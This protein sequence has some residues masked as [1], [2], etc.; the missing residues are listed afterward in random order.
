MKAIKKI[1]PYLF[2]FVLALALNYLFYMDFYDGLIQYGMAHAIKIG[3]LPY[4]DFNTV[5][6]PLYIYLIAPF[7]FLYDDFLTFLIIN[8]ILYTLLYYF[9]NKIL[10]KHQFT[11][12]L[13]TSLPLFPLLS[14]SYNLLAKVLVLLIVYFEIHKKS[15]Y[16]I[17]I[18]LGL[19]IL[20]KHSV[21]LCILLCGF[22]CSF[23]KESILKRSLGV[24]GVLLVFL[25]Y[26]VVTHSFASFFDL[27]ILG[28]FDFQK[29][30]AL[31]SPILIFSIVFIFL[32][33]FILFSNIRKM[34][35]VFFSTMS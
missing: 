27:C 23:K 6:A 28:L 7:L 13:I 9:A 30:N 3:E 12:F 16:Q 11:F 10:T 17:G 8:S 31:S 1:F 2:V 22:L 24:G 35:K 4:L 34:K 32:F 18:L 21:G 25:L 15:D 29:N 19:L 5:V 20:T 14:P 26:L 33:L